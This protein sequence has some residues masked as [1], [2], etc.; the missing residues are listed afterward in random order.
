VLG[1][2]GY[3]L[4]FCLQAMITKYEA[5]SSRKLPLALQILSRDK[6]MLA[7]SDYGDE[8]R[9]LK[10]LAVGHL[11]NINT[12]VARATSTRKLE[13]VVCLLFAYIHLLLSTCALKDFSMDVCDHNIV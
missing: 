10:K 11:L 4:F 9:M 7:L 6:T 1:V 5:I 2:V 3:F 12:Q 13:T 8:H